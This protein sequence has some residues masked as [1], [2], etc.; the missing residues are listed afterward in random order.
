MQVTRSYRRRNGRWLVGRKAQVKP[1]DPERN[2]NF[3]KGG[4]LEAKEMPHAR[5]EEDARRRYCSARTAPPHR[6]KNSSA[7]PQWSSG[8]SALVELEALCPC[9]LSF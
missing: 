4:L 5:H 7:Q 1:D 3:S 9:V 8:A 2:G 6:V